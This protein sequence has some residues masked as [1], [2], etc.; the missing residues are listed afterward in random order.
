MPIVGDIR[1]QYLTVLMRIS[2]GGGRREPVL[3]A[4][5][6]FSDGLLTLSGD[7]E[8]PRREARALERLRPRQRPPPPARFDREV[9]EPVEV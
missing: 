1:S 8:R 2:G 6:G 9:H 3:W 5:A 4:V 7:H